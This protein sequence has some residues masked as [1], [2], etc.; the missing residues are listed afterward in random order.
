MTRYSWRTQGTAS[1]RGD[2]ASIR[3]VGRKLWR[4]T[5]GWR[6]SVRFC[7]FSKMG[8]LTC[9]SA[10]LLFPWAST[11][12]FV[13]LPLLSVV[14]HSYYHRSYRVFAVLI[15]HQHLSF[16][17]LL[18]HFQMAPVSPNAQRDEALV[19]QKTRKQRSDAKRKAYREAQ[20]WSDLTKQTTGDLTRRS[21]RASTQRIYRDHLHVWKRWV[22]A[23]RLTDMTPLIEQLWSRIQGQGQPRSTR[24]EDGQG[25]LD[26]LCERQQRT[27]GP[28]E[29]HL[30]VSQNILEKLLHRLDARNWRRVSHA[31]AWDNFECEIGQAAFVSTELDIWLTI[32]VVY[33]RSQ[34]HGSQLD[35]SDSVTGELY[36]PRSPE[37]VTTA[38]AEWLVRLPPRALS[39]SASLCG[40][41]LLLHDCPSGR[42][43]RVHR[44]KRE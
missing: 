19:L 37:H 21:I 42:V 27:P 3:A 38:L 14:E 9:R 6:W 33:R 4:A 36:L 2:V 23:W 40:P 20:G 25:L 28:D 17:H 43:L 41:A 13:F 35:Y 11:P 34:Q 26:L 10:V 8:A 31:S 22:V 1:S 32:F 7:G 15:F 16:I 5:T 18:L 12:D 39:R 30:I 24:R 29:A 44:K